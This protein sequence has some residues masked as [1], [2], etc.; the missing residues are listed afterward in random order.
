MAIYTQVSDV[1]QEINGIFTYD[2]EVQKLDPTTV[3]G[4]NDKAQTLFENTGKIR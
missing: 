4:L 2:R 1:E 3:R